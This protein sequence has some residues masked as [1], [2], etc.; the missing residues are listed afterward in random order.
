MITLGEMWAITK[1]KP[2]LALFFLALGALIGC[3]AEVETRPIRCAT[4]DV[5]GYTYKVCTE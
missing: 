3:I 5:R 4:S 1:R 2:L